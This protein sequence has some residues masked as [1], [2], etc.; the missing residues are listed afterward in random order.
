MVKRWKRDEGGANG[1]GGEE[2]GEREG[3]VGGGGDCRL[4][5][6]GEDEKT[7]RR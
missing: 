6:I 7:G 1:K 5:V 3:W 4:A 2:E